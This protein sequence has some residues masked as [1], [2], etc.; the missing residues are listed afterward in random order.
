MGDDSGDEDQCRP[1]VDL[2]DHQPGAHV[3][4][5]V[6]RG[7]EGVGHV[8]AVQRR[9]VPVVDDLLGARLKEER[10]ERAREHEHD[11][12]VEG[13]FAEHERP[14]VRKDLVE[15]AAREAG[16]AET[17]IDPANQ[18]ADHDGHMLPHEGASVNARGRGKEAA[19]LPPL[20]T[21]GDLVLRSGA[22]GVADALELRGGAAAQELQGND[23]DDGNQRDEQ[24][25]LDEAGAT[26]VAAQAVLN[27]NPNCYE[28]HERC[29]LVRFCAAR[30]P[31]VLVS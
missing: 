2:A 29:S 8:H 14:M 21:A 11:E 31:R 20:R 10:E 17:V 16:R 28:V 9:V 3:E 15:G 27:V 30:R 13:D 18:P 12:A 22:D 6:D 19:P 1:V 26:V 5:D 7:P 23:A 25:V 4:A 24:D